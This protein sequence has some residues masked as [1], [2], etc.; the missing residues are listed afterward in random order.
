M[1][2]TPAPDTE[3]RIPMIN[4]QSKAKQVLIIKHSANLG[5]KGVALPA[6]K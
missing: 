3:S 5:W 2:N 1:L 4:K 6:G